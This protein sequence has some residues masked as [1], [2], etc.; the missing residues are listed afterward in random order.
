M[1]EFSSPRHLPWEAT[2]N[3]RDLGGHPTA[4]GSTTRHGVFVR[5]DDLCNI[6]P[7]GQ[8]QLIE[9]GIRTVVDLRTPKEWAHRP[10]PFADGMHGVAYHP[11]SLMDPADMDA[12]LR[13]DSIR[14]NGEMYMIFFERFGGQI[15]NVMRTLAEAG[16]GGVLFHCFA[17]KDRT[18]VTAAL[19]LENAG[20]PRPIVALDY[21]ETERY[22]EPINAEW[23]KHIAHLPDEVERAR[24]LMLSP[25]AAMAEALD[26]LDAEHGGVRTYLMQNGVG[27]AALDRLRARLLADAAE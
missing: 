15:G 23:A 26:Y 5:S 1:S 10:H 12:K 7:V 24:P 11:I 13:L 27:E 6:G 4:D 21:A 18:G 19:L 2:Y 25:A 20:V 16:P 17:G 3:V 14:R 9:Y 8:Q 22:S